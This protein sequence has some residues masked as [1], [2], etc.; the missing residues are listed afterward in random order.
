MTLKKSIVL[1]LT[2]FFLS[3]PALS[4]EERGIKAPASESQKPPIL[5]N[6]AA[7]IVGINNYQEWYPLK[8]AVKD[9]RALKDILINQY[10]FDIRFLLRRCAVAQRSLTGVNQR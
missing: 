2:F 6:Y 4:A 5:G 8:T 9:A 7:F 3:S 10:S 1:V